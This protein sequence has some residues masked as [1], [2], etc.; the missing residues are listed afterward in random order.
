MLSENGTS[1]NNTIKNYL[2]SGKED[3]SSSTNEKYGN[4][5]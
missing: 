5:K 2:M 3:A 4:N 1:L